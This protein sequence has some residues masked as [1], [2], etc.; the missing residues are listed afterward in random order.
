MVVHVSPFPPQIP[1]WSS[2]VFEST[3]QSQPTFCSDKRKKRVNYCLN[4]VWY[5]NF[6]H[7]L[8][9][10]C[11]KCTCHLFQYYKVFHQLLNR[12]MA[13]LMCLPNQ[14][15]INHKA[16][17]W[18]WKLFMLKLIWIERML[19]IS[20]HA[21][22]SKE[23]IHISYHDMFHYCISSIDMLENWAH[24]PDMDLNCKFCIECARQHKMLLHFP[25]WK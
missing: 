17:L 10:K 11:Q 12:P 13:Q 15:N 14:C 3:T 1:H 6:D 19:N 21:N 16:R 24:S 8:P 25:V 2:V 22:Q 18:I 4:F 20:T 9:D 5:G 23:A 7:N